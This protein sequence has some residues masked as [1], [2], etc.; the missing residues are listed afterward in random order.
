M[1]K[2]DLKLAPDQ[3]DKRSVIPVERSDVD[4]WLAGTMEDAYQL[5][6][7]APVELFDAGPD[8]SLTRFRPVP[9][10]RERIRTGLMR[11]FSVVSMW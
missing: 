11:R 8:L 6:R 7:L 10:S 1:H 3:Q 9:E 2:P 4:Q 5:L